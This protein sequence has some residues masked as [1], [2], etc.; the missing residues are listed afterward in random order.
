MKKIIYFLGI[1]ISLALFSCENQDEIIPEP[2]DYAPENIESK[3]AT[4]QTIPQWV[5][6]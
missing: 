6:N 3:Y 5:K 4:G 1:V 2:A